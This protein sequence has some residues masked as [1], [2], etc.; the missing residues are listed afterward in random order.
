MIQNL[1]NKNYEI[2]INRKNAINKGIQKLVKNDILLILG[3]GHEK[4]QII[5]KNKIEFDDKKIVLDIIRR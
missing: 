5:G 4:Y 3:K 1:D 2:V